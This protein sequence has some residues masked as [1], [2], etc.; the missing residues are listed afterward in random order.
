M[1]INKNKTTNQIKDEF[2]SMFPHLKLEFFKKK[3]SENEGNK[4]KQMIEENL[5][6]SSLIENK[7][8]GFF[9]IAS[10]MTVS[11]VE[12]SFENN[13]GLHVQIYRKSGDLW[14]QTTATDSWT[15][16]KQSLYAEQNTTV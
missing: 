9:I 7:N 16:E 2:A 12:Q 15:L 1:E 13:F 14:L 6:L 8:E 11:S 3:H 10:D 4:K 5:S